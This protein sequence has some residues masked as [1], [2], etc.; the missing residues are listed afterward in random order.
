MGNDLRFYF[1]L[2]PLRNYMAND[3]LDLLEGDEFLQ[4]VEITLMPPNDGNQSRFQDFKIFIFFPIRLPHIIEV[5]RNIY[6]DKQ[7]KTLSKL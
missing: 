7:F 1:D 2:L 3:V 5:C 4:N 6:K